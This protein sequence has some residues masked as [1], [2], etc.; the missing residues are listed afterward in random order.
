MNTSTMIEKQQE[1]M[2]EQ[3]NE[4]IEKYKDSIVWI[5]I[6]TTGVDPKHDSLF[7]KSL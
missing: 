6:E 4:T 7:F 1:T 3:K 2:L 5:D